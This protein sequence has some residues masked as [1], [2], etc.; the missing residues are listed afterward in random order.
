MLAIILVTLA[1]EVN[2]WILH[3]IR[4]DR[5]TH[6]VRRSYSVQSIR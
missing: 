6:S 5:T 2:L 1:I 3:G 4:R